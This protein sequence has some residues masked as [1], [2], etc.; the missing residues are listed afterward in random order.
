MQ[1]KSNDNGQV[2]GGDA[3]AV[4]HQLFAS[5]V[6]QRLALAVH[7]GHVQVA[8]ALEDE[9]SPVDGPGLGVGKCASVGQVDQV[10]YKVQVRLVRRCTCRKEAVIVCRANPHVPHQT[11]ETQHHG[12]DTNSS[13]E[14]VMGVVIDLRIRA[15]LP[16]VNYAPLLLVTVGMPIGV[17]IGVTICEAVALGNIAIA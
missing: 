13:A 8:D 7:T 10:L 1:A 12:R 11:R 16:A 17:T 9:E 14:L 6:S 4:V 3:G 15:L 2:E 5:H